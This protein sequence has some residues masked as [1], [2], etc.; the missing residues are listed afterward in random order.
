MLV[1]LTEVTQTINF[2]T[3]ILSSQLNTR[4]FSLLH[5]HRA[6]PHGAAVAA[7]AVEALEFLPVEKPLWRNCQPCPWDSSS[8]RQWVQ[9]LWC[10]IAPLAD[11]SLPGC[12]SLQAG[13]DL[14]LLLFLL[15]VLLF[16]AVDPIP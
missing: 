7:S 16:S 14:L 9:A 6:G 3:S 13:A 15:P 12:G 11:M 4:V 2:P 8:E 1:V 10:Q 5:L